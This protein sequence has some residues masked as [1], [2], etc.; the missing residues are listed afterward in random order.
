MSTCMLLL[1]ALEYFTGVLLNFIGRLE[2]GTTFRIVSPNALPITPLKPQ[3]PS[4]W[5]YAPPELHI[6]SSLITKKINISTFVLKPVS[7]AIQ[8]A[9]VDICGFRARSYRA[10]ASRNFT[11]DYTF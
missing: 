6:L 5:V 7:H 10:L 1:L 8:R 2:L 11:H 9:M 3:R 4:Y